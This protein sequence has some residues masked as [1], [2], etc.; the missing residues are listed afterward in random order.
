MHISVI[1][2]RWK[3]V[4][5]HV[6]PDSLGLCDPYDQPRKQITISTKLA[7]SGKDLMLMETAL[8]EIL[9]A[10]CWSLDEEYVEGYAHAAARA[11][12]RLGFRRNVDESEL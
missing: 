5:G 9:H 7:K 6:K 10:A 12:Y 1:G 4:F 3:V 11:L 8:H 2:K